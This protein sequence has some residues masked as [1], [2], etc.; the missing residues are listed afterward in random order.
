MEIT[1]GALIGSVV[2]TGV[3]TK[4]GL[5]VVSLLELGRLESSGKGSPLSLG[6]ISSNLDNVGDVTV[7]D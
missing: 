3:E 2:L 6:G 7:P 4:S 5:A 1:V